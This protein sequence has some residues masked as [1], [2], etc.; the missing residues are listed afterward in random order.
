[1]QSLSDKYNRNLLILIILAPFLGWL[2]YNV[3]DVDV[4]RLMQLLSYVGVA[5]TVISK[6]TYT[7]I[8]FPSYL[9]FYLLFIVY[10]FFSTIY[11]LDRDF[12]FMWLFSNRMIGALNLLFIIENLTINRREVNW[13]LLIGKITVVVAVLVI[14]IQQIYEPTF[15]VRMDEILK[16]EL[17]EEGANTS[18]LVSIYSWMGGLIMVGFGFV[19]LFI[20]I[21]EDSYKKGK[22]VWVWI[23]M[24]LVY[25]LLTKAR[26]IMLNSLFVFLVFFIDRQ[27]NLVR[28]AKFAIGIPVLVLMFYFSLSFIGIN[29]E[30]IVN[31]RILESDKT[32]TEQKT[33]STRVLA[34]KAFDRFFWDHP[35]WGRGNIKYGMGGTGEQD[36]K[37]RS[38]LKGHSSQIHVGYL[39]LFYLYGIVGGTLFM[40][41]LYRLMLKVYKESKRTTY[42]GP[43]LGILGF[44]VANLTLVT[45]TFFEVGLIVSMIMHKYYVQNSK[46]N[47]SSVQEDFSTPFQ[48]A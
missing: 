26:W 27:F 10:D 9:L 35:I 11:L 44:A 48:G 36:Y 18:R 23:L 16:E 1:M 43:Y 8:K 20:L 2:T 24:G 19:P 4:L 29:V 32:R 25:A 21:V 28:V 38:F 30:G 46:L 31:D 45:F 15:F 42:W 7:D 5:L 14:I 40:F 41:F 6:R 22:I 39:S 12:Q 17:L 3:L 34:V 37:L 13:I 33:F 47:S